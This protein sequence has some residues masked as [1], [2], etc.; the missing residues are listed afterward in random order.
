MEC[1]TT[2]TEI[3]QR[4]AVMTEWIVALGIGGLL[5]AVIAALAVH[6]TR[7]FITLSNY[8][9]LGAQS[10]LAVDRM[11][12]ELRQALQVTAYAPDRITFQLD[13]NR[14]T[15][16]FVAAEKRLTRQVENGTRETLLKGCDYARF[17]IFQ[18]QA[19]NVTL[20]SGV[21]KLLSAV[22][23]SLDPIYPVATPET[24]KIVQLTWTCSRNIM[25]RKAS[26]EAAQFARIV[27]RKQ[28]K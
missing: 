4:G 22:P 15:Y 17:D 26:T 8:V 14:I 3:R 21:S 23:V 25:G 20:T 5:L 18:R 16:A 28:S 27:I 10:R 1:K 13:T 6:S 9:D 11:G 12:Q 2:S 7:S 19:T 24:A